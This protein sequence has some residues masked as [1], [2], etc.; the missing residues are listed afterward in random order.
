[1]NLTETV[2]YNLN[3]IVREHDL[4]TR[5]LASRANMNQKSVWNVLTMEHSP[6]LATL[7]P[8]CKTLLASPMAVVTPDVPTSMLISRRLPRFVEKYKRLN[9]AQREQVEMLLDKLLE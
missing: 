1:M 6:R 3:K 7:E 4:S 5:E 2:A 9:M 8:I